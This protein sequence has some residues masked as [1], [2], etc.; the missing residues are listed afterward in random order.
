MSL[1]T[2]LGATVAVLLLVGG[3]FSSAVRA[4]P[5][6][7][8]PPN[9][10]LIMVDDLGYGDLSS[11]GADTLR[12]PH[13]DS[14]VAAGLR[15][16]RF[17]ANSPVCSPT[18]ASLLTGQYPDR[19]GV[20]GVIR[21]HAR[22]SW[23]YLS[24]EEVLLPRVLAW[25]GYHT[26][27]VG[28]WHLGLEPPNTPTARG[29]DV[30][31]GFLGDMMDDYYTHRRHGINYMRRND[32]VIDPEGHATTLFTDW[33]SEYVR[34]RAASSAPFFLYLAYNA[35]HSPI[36]PPEEWVER[37]EARAPDLSEERREIVALIEHLD[38]GVG[39]VVRALRETG[40]YENTMIV[41]TSDNGGAL[42]HGARNGPLRGGK[43]DMYEGGLRVPTA[44]TWPG[45]VASGTRTEHIGLTMDLY[46]TL[47]EVA[48]ARLTRPVDGRSLL[49]VLR[50]GAEPADDPRT[51][52]WV[53]REGGPAYMGQAAYAVRRGPWKLLQNRPGEPFRL[54]H[55]GRDPREQTD[56]AAD[57]P[58]QVEALSEALRRHIQAA[59]R[60]PW[61]PPR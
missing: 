4:Q 14:L 19:A 18:R 15:F 48:G 55:L 38:H 30:F 44:V 26:A 28:K 16:D 21:T 29:F 22:N 51:L 37:V 47:A 39:R 58:E 57:H 10:V 7:S 3:P 9:V 27:M 31:R 45:R 43:Q 33:A 50:D 20:P 17:Y 34:D 25:T 1:R 56:V 42:Y 24:P 52:F 49:P 53:R 8:G 36:Q 61:Q 54:Y 13:I 5:G 40:A 12:T 60:V 23:G 32:E 6:A 35:P 41:F 11:Y 2:A 59:G 46:P